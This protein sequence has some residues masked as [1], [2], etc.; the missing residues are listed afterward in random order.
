M[1]ERY[2]KHLWGANTDIV[3]NPVHC[4]DA[5][6]SSSHSATLKFKKIVCSGDAK[7]SVDHSATLIIDELECQNL[8]IEVSY[9][10]TLRI[11]NLKCPGTVNINVTYSSTFVVD[12]GSAGTT[13]GIINYSS[14]G[15]FLA[16]IGTDRVVAE[17]ASTWVT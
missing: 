17:N 3:S 13:A 12:G 5:D 4:S 16:S 15:K 1:S 8:T 2:E 11:G 10:S 6:I 14:L 9:A 7:L